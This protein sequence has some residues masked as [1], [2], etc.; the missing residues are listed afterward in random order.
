MI[1][2]AKKAA[3]LYLGHNLHPLWKRKLHF[4]HIYIVYFHQIYSSE[5]FL[6]AYIN[7][8]FPEDM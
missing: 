7:N 6:G 2:I 3:P 8:R 5:S 1:W 4:L